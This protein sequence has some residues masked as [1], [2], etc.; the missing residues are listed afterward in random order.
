MKNVNHKEILAYTY[1]LLTGFQNSNMTAIQGAIDNLTACAAQAGMGAED[2]REF[3]MRFPVVQ[4]RTRDSMQYEFMFDPHFIVG[5]LNDYTEQNALFY[6][7]HQCQGV[8]REGDSHRMDDV[9]GVIEQLAYQEPERALFYNGIMSA[10]QGDFTN[11]LASLR[12]YVRIVEALVDAG[13]PEENRRFGTLKKLSA[14]IDN[15]IMYYGNEPIW[16]SFYVR[17]A[18][19]RVYFLLTLSRID[20]QGDNEDVIPNRPESY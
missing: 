16:D 6:V 4:T 9:Y 14:S 2:S 19:N 13:T 1:R 5:Y 8:I 17:Q 3:T 10:I 12:H 20:M 7:L 15:I 11:D 18:S